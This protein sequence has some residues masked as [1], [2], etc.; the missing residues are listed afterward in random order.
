[1]VLPKCREARNGV[2][3]HVQEEEDNMI[4]VNPSR[5]CHKNINDLKNIANSL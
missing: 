4:W 1:M 5:L 2:M 3:Q